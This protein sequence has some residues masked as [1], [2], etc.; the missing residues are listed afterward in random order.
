MLASRIEKPPPPVERIPSVFAIPAMAAPSLHAIRYRRFRK[1]LAICSY[2]VMAGRAYCVRRPGR[3]TL[4]TVHVPPLPTCANSTAWAT[5]GNRPCINRNFGNFGAAF[6]HATQFVTQ[7][8]YPRWPSTLIENNGITGSV[9]PALLTPQKDG[10]GPCTIPETS[11]RQAW[12]LRKNPSGAQ[13][14]LSRATMFS[15][16]AAVSSSADV[17]TS[18]QP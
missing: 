18:N 1:R 11:L 4:R 3:H 9:H 10:S 13:I 12:W 16:R 6:A 14:A 5:A 17:L 2:C 8:R 15:R 7:Q